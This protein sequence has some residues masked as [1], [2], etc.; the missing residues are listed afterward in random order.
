MADHTRSATTHLGA[1]GAKNSEQLANTALLLFG[2]FRTSVDATIDQ[3]PQAERGEPV[4]G[5]G[6]I[7]ASVSDCDLEP[8]SSLPFLAGV[9]DG[10]ERWA[11]TYD[12]FPNPVLAREQRYIL[13]LLPSLRNRHVLDLACGTGRWLER[14]LSAGALPGVGVDLS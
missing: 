8:P 3:P 7:G 13:P 10:Y 14:L 4:N 12:D 9:R 2:T 1:V 11:P 6:R 5:S